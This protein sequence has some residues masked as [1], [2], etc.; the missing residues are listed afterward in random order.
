MSQFLEY[1]VQEKYSE[2]LKHF[3]NKSPEYYNINTLLQFSY[4]LIA[5]YI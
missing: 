1:S 5:P 3:L 2:S 4:N